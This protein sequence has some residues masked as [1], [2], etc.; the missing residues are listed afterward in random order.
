M[1]I[2]KTQS[3]ERIQSIRNVTICTTVH[4]QCEQH[5]L[6]AHKIS[7]NRHIQHTKCYF[8]AELSAALY[9]DINYVQIFTWQNRIDLGARKLYRHYVHQI[10]LANYKY[11]QTKNRNNY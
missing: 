4:L 11:R 6:F 3:I 8:Y 7:L 2:L 10:G 5:S 1:D 9:D